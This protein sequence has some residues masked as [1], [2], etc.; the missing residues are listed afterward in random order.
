MH[1]VLHMVASD[2]ERYGEHRSRHVLRGSKSR[3]ECQPRMAAHSATIYFWVSLCFY[4]YLHRAG[5]ILP[6]AAARLPVT[7]TSNIAGKH[8][9]Y[10]PRRSR[11][12]GRRHGSSLD[13]LSHRNRRILYD[14]LL[15]HQ[16]RAQPPTGAYAVPFF[17]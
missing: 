3:A 15:R 9:R 16:R 4:L 8:P 14:L 12:R 17:R 10:V 11:Y 2:V 5:L 6:K 7:L 13:A 1:S